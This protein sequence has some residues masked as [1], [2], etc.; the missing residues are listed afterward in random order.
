MTYD[1]INKAV[2]EINKAFG[3]KYRLMTLPKSEKTESA[4]KRTV[5]YKAQDNKDSKGNTMSNCGF[6]NQETLR[7][8]AYAVVPKTKANKTKNKP[9][10][11]GHYYV[12]DADLKEFSNLKMDSLGR[13]VLNIL[14][15]CRRLKE[16]RGAGLTRYAVVM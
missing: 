8:V 10:F 4:K 3:A 14:R 6:Q 1:H 7:R 16:I 13:A 15:H 5:A 9:T 12:V 11:S 2:D